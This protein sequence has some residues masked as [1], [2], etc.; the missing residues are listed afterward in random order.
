MTIYT[1]FIKFCINILRYMSKYSIIFLKYNQMY[2][3]TEVHQF[4]VLNF[5]LKNIISL[6]TLKLYETRA[7]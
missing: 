2:S 7:N 3:N 4:W 5:C 1:F 6:Y